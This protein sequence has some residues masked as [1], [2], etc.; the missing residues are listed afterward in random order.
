MLTFQDV[1][2]V[3]P[4]FRGAKDEQIRF[5][6]LLLD[7][8][9]NGEKGLFIALTSF[10]ILKAIEQGAIAAMWPSNQPLPAAVPT[11]FPVFFVERVD[12]A[13]LTLLKT[14]LQ[15]LNKEEWEQMTNIVFTK[16]KLLNDWIKTYDRA[17]KKEIF[18]CITKL[19]Q[20]INRKKG[21]D[22]RC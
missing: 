17:I 22:K 20:H 12:E 1:S 10:D 7:L 3:C 14:Y 8:S 13:L 15:K 19:Q 4:N 16:D 11:L 9:L 21:G 6:S 18:R 2:T 5:H